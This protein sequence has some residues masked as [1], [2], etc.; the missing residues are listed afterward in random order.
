VPYKSSPL[1]TH[2]RRSHRQGHS[3]QEVDPGK[4][5]AS[6]AAY[7]PNEAKWD[8]VSTYAEAFAGHSLM[9]LPGPH[10][11][12]YC[13]K[14]RLLKFSSQIMHLLDG[15]TTLPVVLLPRLP[16]VV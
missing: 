13:P 5:R 3:V 9:R 1:L 16:A 10:V 7:R 14:V 15:L 8:A 6:V 2:R 4:D 11:P 12:T